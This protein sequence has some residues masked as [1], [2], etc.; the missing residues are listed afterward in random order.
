[1]WPDP[2]ETAELVR[3]TEEILN[4]KLHFFCTVRSLADH[5]FELSLWSSS[6]NYQKWCLPSQIV[7]RLFL[8]IIIFKKKTLGKFLKNFFSFQEDFGIFFESRDKLSFECLVECIILQYHLDLWSHSTTDM[9]DV[10]RSPS[11][12]CDGASFFEKS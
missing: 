2:Q 4:G 5:F 10:F 9:R 12:I 6:D 3:F 7:K 8:K 11:D 1:M